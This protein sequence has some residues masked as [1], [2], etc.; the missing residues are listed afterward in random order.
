[1]DAPP[2]CDG[3][4][5]AAA[6]GARL[7]TCASCRAAR[8]C[9]RACQT[10]AW[11]AHRRACD[12]EA[13]GR[14]CDEAVSL[15]FSRAHARARPL[16]A[17]AAARAA[18][19]HGADSLVAAFLQLKHA[20]LLLVPSAAPRSAAE[21]AQDWQAGVLLWRAATAT[22]AARRGAGTALHGACRGEETAFLLRQR[23]AVVA[24]NA[25]FR[26]L[27]PRERSHAAA[28]APALGYAL[29]SQAAYLALVWMNPALFG[30]QRPVAASERAP[31]EAIVLD[32]LDLIGTSAAFAPPLPLLAEECQLC[33][34]LRRLCDDAMA[35]P[36]GAPPQLRM[37]PAFVAALRAKWAS[38]PVAG[39]LRA[40]GMDSVP[41]HLL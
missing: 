14:L 16:L 29:Y 35:P 20:E 40:R 11:R 6:A 37:A 30:V 27:S 1:M 3:C 22:L 19:L 7:K 5:G 34:S 4:G 39:A 41:L 17:Q 26:V 18:Q 23:C 13:F 8:Y 28:Q 9:S 31:A 10:A 24:A 32:A 33:A 15:V 12:A 21:Q 2:T 36:A 38:A 25:G